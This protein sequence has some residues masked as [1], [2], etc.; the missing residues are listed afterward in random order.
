MLYEREAAADVTVVSAATPVIVLGPRMLAEATP[1]AEIRAILARAVELTRPAH[2]VF[3][4]LPIADATRLIASAVRLFGPPALREATSALVADPDVQRGHDEM[5]RAGLSV[6]VRARSSSCSPACPQPRSMSG[7][8]LAAC[9]RSAR[10]RRLA[11]RRRSGDESPRSP[12][13]A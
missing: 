5:V 10:S 4:G 1:L 6:K 7:A 12:P 13:R 8:N 11:A 2:V 3:A 9:E